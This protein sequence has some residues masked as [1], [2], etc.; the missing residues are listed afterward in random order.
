M[1]SLSTDLNAGAKVATSLWGGTGLASSAT[2]GSTTAQARVGSASL[3]A[4]LVLDL[5]V[6]T[7]PGTYSGSLT[8]PLFPVD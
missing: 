5:P 4:D 3:N 8:V 7:A 6:E 1:R 2:R